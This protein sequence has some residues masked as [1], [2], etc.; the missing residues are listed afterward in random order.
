ML[1]ISIFI[2]LLFHE[3]QFSSLLHRTS[4]SPVR[5]SMTPGRPG[6]GPPEPGSYRVALPRT[7]YG[8][9]K[10]AAG[11]VAPPSGDLMTQSMDPGHLAGNLNSLDTMTTS[12]DP[13][14]LE[15][16]NNQ[17]LDFRVGKKKVTCLFS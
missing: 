10:T 6:S 5:R 11:V 13:N 16:M 12:C 17:N 4:P 3:F 8:D 14:M 9:A 7:L 2:G 15:M 1:A